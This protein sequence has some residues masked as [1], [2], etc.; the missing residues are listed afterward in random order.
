M[1]IPLVISPDGKLGYI[2]I[3][4]CASTTYNFHFQRRLGWG[5]AWRDG[6][7]MPM[8]DTVFNPDPEEILV[9]TRDPE[10]RL[11]SAERQEGP[12]DPDNPH[13]WPIARCLRDWWHMEDRMTFVDVDDVPAWLQANDLPT[14]DDRLNAATI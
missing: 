13:F 2:P 4:K 7:I 9:I 11:R 10:E 3:P 1:D 6:L 14:T 12:Y 5:R 8:K